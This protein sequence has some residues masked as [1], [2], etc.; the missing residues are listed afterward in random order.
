MLLSH[1]TAYIV[2]KINIVRLTMINM[3]PPILQLL[4]E[5]SIKSHNT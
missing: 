4:K 2:V 5:H 1:I 3:I